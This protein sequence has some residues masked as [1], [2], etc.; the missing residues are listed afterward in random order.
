MNTLMTTAQAAELILSGRPLLLAGDE[1]LLRALPRG[2]WI[3][4]TIPYFMTA[5]GGALDHGRIFVTD[6]PEF[7]TGAQIRSYA[8]D[9]L[10][11]IPRDYPANGVSFII[12]PAFSG[13]HSRYARECQSWPELFLRPLLGWVAGV[14]LAELGQKTPKVFDGAT[15][16]VFADRA[17]VLHASLPEGR[18]AKV[19]IANIFTQGA[20]SALTFDEAGF[21]ARTCRVDGVETNFAAWLREREVNTKLPLVADYAGAMV[22]VSIQDAGAESGVVSLYAPVFPE[23]E[24]RVARPVGDYAE[25]FRAVLEERRVSPAFTCNCILNFLYGELEGKH[26]GELVGPITF[27]EIAYVLLNQT[28]VYLTFESA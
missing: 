13:A 9:A 20:G 21:Q 11:H 19:D 5:E 8:E 10:P 15:G 7:V 3:G 1:E 25:A 4:G 18:Y 23:R 2:S 22:N 6:L 17:V 28:M 27:G 26:T 14:D 16:E 12:L 24:Y